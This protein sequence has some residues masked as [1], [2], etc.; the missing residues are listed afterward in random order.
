MFEI[1][2]DM[3]QCKDEKLKKTKITEKWKKMLKIVWKDYEKK[4]EVLRKSYNSDTDT[5]HMKLQDHY[6]FDLHFENH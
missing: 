2:T 1:H 6:S 4:V 3:M 5:R